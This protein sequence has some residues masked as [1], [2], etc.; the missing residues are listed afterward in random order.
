MELFVTLRHRNKTKQNIMK[1]IAVKI[2][3][4]C[5]L[6]VAGVVVTSCGG[7]GTLLQTL[8]SGGT[9][10]NA[11]TSVIG[12]DKVTKQGMV[13]TWHYDSPGCAFTSE[14][15]LA[16]AGGE[17][18]A[19]KIE[20]EM[21]P[22]FQKTGI[23]AENTT[24]TFNEDGSFQ[25]KI[26]GKSF[27]GTWTLDESTAKVTMKGLLLSINCYAKREYGGISLLFESKKLLNVLQVMAAMSGN[28]TVQ[29][30]GDLSKN[31]DGIRLG[32]DMKK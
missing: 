11:F 1:K 31:Y 20:Q 25:A 9:L 30:V 32:F 7:A 28:D 16:K 12:L 13:G 6:L 17:V 2:S 21:A 27:S 10:A 5:L 14:N 19:T 8:G 23:N 15:L 24:V 3:A 4:F 26:A 22:Y 29:K 18:A